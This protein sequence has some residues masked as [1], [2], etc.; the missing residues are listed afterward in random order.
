MGDSKEPLLK[1]KSINVN[2][3]D[4]EEEKISPLLIFLI[5]SI[6]LSPFN[7]GYN[8]GV[9]NSPKNAIT[10]MEDMCGISRNNGMFPSCIPMNDLQWSSIVSVFTIGG[11]I[12]GLI[13]GK[14]A[15]HFGRR[16][17][18][19][20]NNCIFLL[21]SILLSFAVN[22]EMLIIGRTV[23]GLACGISSVVVPIYLSE[24]SPSRLRGTIGTLNQLL[25]TIGILVS[26]LLGIIWSSCP[27]WRYL[28]GIPVAVVSILQLVI[29]PFCPNSPTWLLSKGKNDEAKAAL[30]LL[31][32]KEV[33]VTSELASLKARIQDNAVEG[34]FSDLYT[35][36]L[37]TLIICIGLQCAQQLSGINVVFFYSTDIFNKA[38][39]SNSAVATAIIGTINVLITVIAA[40][41]MDRVG[42]RPILLFSE[43]FMLV[44]LLMLALSMIFSAHIGQSAGYI[45]VASVILFVIGFA[46]GLGPIPWLIVSELF[47][48]SVRGYAVS[49]SVGVNWTSNF[50]VALSFPLI[51]NALG[52][53]TFIL[54]AVIV[55]FFTIFTWI[56]LPETKGKS[57][58]Q[59]SDQKDEIST[60]LE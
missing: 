26:E 2:Q 28:L 46:V 31:R 34:K 10:C 35:R 44:F 50:I 7:F 36:Y 17:I 30:S 51:Q 4:K 14:L 29:L 20:L 27:S 23:V 38:G 59:L 16:F 42:R 11:L 43:C 19:S 45:L 39:I 8:T 6:V 57:I 5:S 53:Y 37:R 25:L 47:P 48:T 41:L 60:L 13:A 12:G 33:D 3:D 24:I 22:F 21:G 18:L 15:D 1:T 54:F 56:L 32:G 58:E 9:I 49:I 55:F 52:S 40:F